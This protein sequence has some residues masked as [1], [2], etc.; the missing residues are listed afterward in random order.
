MAQD[1][2]VT[3]PA[4]WNT[5]VSL[6]TDVPGRYPKA[7]F[8]PTKPITVTRVE[9]FTELGP[10]RVAALGVLPTEC[11]MQ[12]A[13]ELSSGTISRTIPLSTSFSKE[14]IRRTLIVACSTSTFLR[15]SRLLC[16]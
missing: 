7:M 16:L 3:T 15:V 5:Q 13:L 6:T 10:K 11:P 1:K 12:Y 2:A 9:G 14:P 8:T 4:V